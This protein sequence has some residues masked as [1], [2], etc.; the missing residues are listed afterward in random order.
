M[1]PHTRPTAAEQMLTTL[2][3]VW[4]LVLT[5]APAAAFYP[6]IVYDTGG[7]FDKS[8]NQAAYEGVLRFKRATGATVH[9]YEIVE[10]HDRDRFI[11]QA[12]AR[13]ATLVIAVGFNFTDAVTTAAEHH[14]DVRFT[15]IDSIIEAPNVQSIIFEENEGSFLV[16]ALAAMISDTGTIGFVGGMDIPVIRR[17]LAG[18]V[19][20]AHHA[21]PDI[22]VLWR[23]TGT[24]PAAF[25]DPFTGALIAFDM[26]HEGAD[27]LYAAAGRT[28]LGVY[29]AAREAR[30]YAIGVDSDQ[31]YLHPG[32]MLTSMIKRVDRAVEQTLYAGL[33]ETWVPG[34][35]ALGL[36]EGGV[37]YAVNSFNR[38]LLDPAVTRRLETARAEIVAGRLAVPSQF[39]AK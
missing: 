9:D 25:A 31:T 14:S 29:V 11:Q 20:G 28:G 13:G 24:T 30:A 18:Y 2:L 33:N 21:R 37:D 6:A 39:P 3:S 19:A 22:E 27:V 5:C 34:V 10:G 12:I 17:F 7:R 26:L 16:G 32:T 36:A 1:A 4:L 38:D 35:L 23:M 15:I 8:F